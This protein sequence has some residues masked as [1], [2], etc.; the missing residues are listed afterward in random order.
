MDVFK[1]HQSL[2]GDYSSYIHSFINIRDRRMS[3]FIKDSLERGMLWP[4]PLIQLSPSFELAENIDE[5]VGDGVLHKACQDIFRKDKDNNS[6]GKEI[7]LYRH[8]R[9]AIAAAKRDQNYVL[10]TGTGSGKRLA[11]FVPIVD[12]ILK[13]GPGNDQKARF[14]ESILLNIPIPPMYVTSYVCQAG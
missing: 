4:E 5:L 10:T 13:E 3:D 9:E 7:R 8:Q 14:I 11:Y 6:P 1:L 12:S 2:M